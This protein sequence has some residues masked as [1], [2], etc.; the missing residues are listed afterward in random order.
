MSPTATLSEKDAAA[1]RRLTDVHLK[2]VLDHDPEAFLKT[3]TDD[4]HF[5][6]PDQP[7]VSGR[8]ACRAYL[9]DFPTPKTFTAKVR[10]VEGEGDL[11]Y[12]R[13]DATATFDDGTETTF[14]W[15]AIVR[16]QRDGSW[17]MARDMWVTP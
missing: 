15:L 1:I 8:D 2:A 12:S 6:P 17:K 16:R 3:C 4:I 5:F 11:A 7:A 13:G 14:T 9:A 10:D